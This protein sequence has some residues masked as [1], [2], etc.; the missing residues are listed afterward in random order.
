MGDVVEF[1]QRLDGQ[2][3]D[4][5]SVA[6]QD[7]RRFCKRAYGFMV[8]PPRADRSVC[9]RIDER[10]WLISLQGDGDSLAEYQWDGARMIRVA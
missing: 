2:R 3:I 9:R 4:L 5:I 8:A 7:Y 1:P 10:H 6:I